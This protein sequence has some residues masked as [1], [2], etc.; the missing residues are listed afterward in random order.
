MARILSLR[1][2]H[3]ETAARPTKW[4]KDWRLRWFRR[5]GTVVDHIDGKGLACLYSDDRDPAARLALQADLEA[6][7]NGVGQVLAVCRKVTRDWN[8]KVRAA[9]AAHRNASRLQPRE[10]SA[11]HG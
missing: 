3:P 7:P 6:R 4:A 9:N 1:Y 5:V 10:G 8:T 11:R 2:P